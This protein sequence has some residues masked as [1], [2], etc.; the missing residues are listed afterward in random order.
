MVALMLLPLLIEIITRGILYR[1]AIQG[2]MYLL[3]CILA[4]GEMSALAWFPYMIGTIVIE[5]IKPAPLPPE[6]A[7]YTPKRERQDK[8]GLGGWFWKNIPTWVIENGSNQL[9]IAGTR[10]VAFSYSNYSRKVRRKSGRQLNRKLAMSMRLVTITCM[11]AA[12]IHHEAA[13]DS[14]SKPI[15]IDNCSSR[16]LTNS[17]RDFLPGTVEGCNVAV[18]G[19]GGLIRCKKKGTVSWTIEDDQGRSHDVLIP[20]TPMCSA[21]PTRLFSPQHWAQEVERKSRFPI[22]G[23]WRPHCT[24]NA[25]TTTLTWG[26][27]KFT[28]TV[29]LDKNKNVAI[30]STRPGIKK[31]SSFATTVQGL[32]PVISCFVATGAPYEEAPTVTDNEDSIDDVDESVATE[33]SSASE[34]DDQQP[35]QAD[36]QEQSNVQGVSIENDQPLSKDKDEL[37]RLHVRAGHLSFAKIRAM[38]RR[39]EVPSRLQ[40]CESP[41]CAACQYGKATRKPWRTKRKGRSIRVATMPGECVS[42]DQLESRQV[43]FVAQLKGRLTLGR[44]RVA[45]IFVDHNSRLGYVHVQKDS[46]SKETLMAKHAFE[47]YARER[48]VTVKNY[49]ADNGRFVDNAWKEALAQENQGITYGR[50]G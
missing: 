37:Y 21:L 38:A 20:D 30:M 33:E 7:S 18:S 22:L 16:C 17:S 11:T 45:T 46:T 24:T 40:H 47:L 27:G 8:E 34:G 48:G 49:H 26:R 25:D 50:T 44:Y 19:V 43:G 23:S 2:G 13:F 42:V 15:A 1:C 41:M 12:S 31:Y 35:E 28:K 6:Q 10:R 36:F 4:D 5:K 9:A 3:W 14:D 32:E 29:T 39:G